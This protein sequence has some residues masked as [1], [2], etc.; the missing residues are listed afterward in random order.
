MIAAAAI[1]L[2]A[3]S[4]LH[5]YLGETRILAPLLGQPP[6]GALKSAR[7]R[8]ILRGA[9][10]VTSLAWVAMAILLVLSS[11]SSLEAAVVWTTLA[12]ACTTSAVCLISYGPSHPGFI[13]FTLCALVLAA[14]RIA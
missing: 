14:Q 1:L 4:V 13:A 2:V 12:L 5:S 6:Q 10:H 8:G 9:W 7:V 11:G 3:T